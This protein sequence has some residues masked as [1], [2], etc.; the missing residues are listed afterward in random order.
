MLSPYINNDERQA[1]V[2]LVGWL[3]GQRGLGGEGP[4]TRP[5]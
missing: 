1:L 2:D 4:R 5:V 3:R